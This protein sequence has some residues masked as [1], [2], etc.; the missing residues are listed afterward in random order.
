MI[1]MMVEG[2]DETGS[3]STDSRLDN[4]GMPLAMDLTPSTLSPTH[5]PTPNEQHG[6]D[7][8]VS[9]WGSEG[10]VLDQETILQDLISDTMTPVDVTGNFSSELSGAILDYQELSIS[11]GVSNAQATAMQDMLQTQDVLGNIL[12]KLRSLKVD[13]KTLAIYTPRYLQPHVFGE[14]PSPE[15]IDLESDCA[16]ADSEA[17]A[18]RM[19]TVMQA[20]RD[21]GFKLI[22]L[23]KQKKESRKPSYGIC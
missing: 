5:A 9:I 1:D 11:T 13:D 23:A 10:N 16:T 3:T 7:S 14:L 6:N 20:I 4:D 2:D 15:P 22:P 8:E 18:T 12:Q 21:E 19:V 17:A